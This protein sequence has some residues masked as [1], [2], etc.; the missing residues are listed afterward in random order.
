MNTSLYQQE[1]LRHASDASSAGEIEN[2][3]RSATIDNPLCGDRIKVDLNLSDG[4]ITRYAHDTKAC[5]LCQASAAMIGHMI[6]GQN[7][8]AFDAGEQALTALLAGDAIAPAAPF[9][10]FKI[11]SSVAAH[12]SRHQCVLLPFEAVRAA[13]NSED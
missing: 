9:E 7:A 1:L 4:K 13:L 10:D 5:V 2:P 6:I 11:F 3:D 12:Q 8:D